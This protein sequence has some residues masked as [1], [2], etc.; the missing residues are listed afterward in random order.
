MQNE[1]D[2]LIDTI[3]A[4]GGSHLFLFFLV[5]VSHTKVGT[6]DSETSVTTHHH[7]EFSVSLPHPPSCS[8]SSQC[9][10][11][12]TDGAHI[13]NNKLGRR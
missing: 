11:A 5:S 6:R 10:S 4:A 13:R 1:C 9:D 8:R 3:M 2:V 12:E 7:H